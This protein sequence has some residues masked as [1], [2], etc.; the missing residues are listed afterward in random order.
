MRNCNFTLHAQLEEPE[1][2]QQRASQNIDT[3]HETKANEKH[4]QDFKIQ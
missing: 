1:S 3:V 4:N 2:K